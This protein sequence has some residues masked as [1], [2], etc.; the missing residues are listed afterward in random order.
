MD[1]T[2]EFLIGVV[3]CLAVFGLAE[4]TGLG[5]DRSFYATVLIVVATYYILFAVMGTS[6][7]A[8]LGELVAAGLFLILAIVGF[9]KNLWIVAC[10][11]AGHGVFDFFHQLLI[12]NSGVPPWWPGFCGAFDVVAG[13]LLAALLIRRSSLARA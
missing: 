13:G 7:H 8:L 1:L 2:M 10:A 9:R 4:L 6:E 5:R 11:L 12:D 3:L